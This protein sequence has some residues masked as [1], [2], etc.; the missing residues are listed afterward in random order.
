M[1]RAMQILSLVSLSSV[2]VTAGACTV[3]KAAGGYSIF[4]TVYNLGALIRG[5]FPQA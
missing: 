2:Y 5:L 3:T 1:K 4:P